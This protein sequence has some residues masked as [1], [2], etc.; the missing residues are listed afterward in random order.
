[1]YIT[2]KAIV[3]A[4]ATAA[5]IAG[6]TTAFAATSAEL[7]AQIDALMA[8]L[9]A[10]QGTVTVTT[11]FTTDLTIGSTG[12]QVVALQ[13][14]LE[15]KG[16][17]VM[18]VGVAKGYFGGLTKAALARFQA[19]NGIVPAVGYFGPITRGRVNAM[20]VTS[21][22]GGGVVVVVPG[23]G[24]GALF[25][26]TTGQPC[27]GGTSTGGSTVLAGA[28][29]LINVEAL[30]AVESSLNEGDTNQKVVGVEA[31][32][33]GGDVMVQRLDVQ[34]D[35]GASSGSSNLDRYID[36]A[37]V[38]LDGKKLATMDAS[39]ADKDGRVWT[40]RFNNLNGVIKS[41]ATGQL[42]VS[43]NAVS[44]IDA[45]EANEDITVT[46]P[47]NGLRAVSGDGISDT[48]VSA[49]IDESFSVD[50]ATVGK[51]TI[52]EDSSNPDD[53]VVTADSNNT[54]DDVTLLA[55]DLKAKNQDVMVDAIPVSITAG[56]S[57]YLSDVVS[58]VSLMKGS[59]VLRTK[60][61]ASST[62][63]SATSVVF[64]NLNQ[65]ISEDSTAKYTVVANIRKINDGNT[66]ADSDTVV[67]SVTTSGSWDAEDA[68]GDTATLTGS[69]TGGTIALQETG[70]SATFVSG[71][72]SVVAGSSGVS[73][74]GN[75]VLKYK[76]TASGDD[77]YVDKDCSAGSTAAA[78]ST[79]YLATGSTTSTCSLT[80]T[81]DEQTNSFIV[82]DGT[83]ETFT[84]NVS[85]TPNSTGFTRVSLVGIGY[86]LTDVDGTLIYSAN[87]DDFKTDSVNLIKR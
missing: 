60:S 49:D 67:A 11:T 83:S 27:S 85:A 7:Q 55:F 61:I 80:S 47:E 65:T 46:I 81:A 28:G 82:R 1:M 33:R 41:G 15:Q 22:N 17:L 64:D 24:N 20:L 19:A 38:W 14:F 48:Y 36:S 71:S 59:T 45:N 30:G 5:M 58:S 43:V 13:T 87:L 79:R 62:S 75:F 9:A 50:T 25:S 6:A 18:P 42:S 78:T 3:S 16:F 72:A 26:S 56:G 76:V 57:T 40:M 2:K 35:L 39:D 70:I 34:F 66:F 23:C 12:S 77:M 31:E 32:A 37:S 8:Q 54:T 73:D 52:S 63:F 69:A 29:R 86:A 4:M 44:S 51:L 10:A 68:N 84:L 21:G 74:T 53:Q